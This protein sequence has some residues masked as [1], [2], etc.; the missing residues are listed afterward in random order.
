MKTP[1][2]TAGKTGWQT[3][4]GRGVSFRLDRRVFP[5][6]LVLI[7]FTAAVLVASI[8]YGQYAMT[9]LDVMATLFGLNADH[10]DYRNFALVVH[11]FRLPRILVAFAV[12][13]AL[14][15]A[16]TLMQ[17]VTRN[18]LAD[19]YLLGVSGG[20]GLVAVALIVWF[21]DAPLALLP[22]GTFAGGFAVALANYLFAWRRGG[23][24]P[25]RLVLIGIGLSALVG[26][27]ITAMLLFGRVT[28][29]QQAYVWLTGS[30]YARTWE[31]VRTLGV[32]L[33][34]LLPLTFMLAGRL[35][36]LNLGD[37]TARSVGMRVE[38]GRAFLLLLSVALT[39]VSVAVAG[40][41][42]FVGLIAPHIARRL[43][44]PSHEG[45]LPVSALVG[46]ALVVSADL[47]GRAVVAPSELPVGLVTAM[48]GAPYFAYLLIRSRTRA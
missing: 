29:V 7:A 25:I 35:N 41:V 48:L 38:R 2:T 37:D 34:V 26:A 22:L 12:G 20:A 17:G 9:P 15:V 31:H 10:P 27:L 16:G 45:L 33:V 42:G 39:A 14:A 3:V 28:D 24:T 30:V 18:P 46:G 23:S 4:R 5:V 40:T 21:E 11:T 47:L 32:A 1:M 8:T 36:V 13:M 43:V 44:G 19:P 6:A